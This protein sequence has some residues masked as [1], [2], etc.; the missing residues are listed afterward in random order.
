MKFTGIVMIV[1]SS[2]LIGLYQANKLAERCQTVQEV[3]TLIRTVKIEMHY[4]ATT[5]REL[6]E[7]L[8]QSSEFKRLNFFD[9]CLERYEEG[10]DQV[11]EEEVGRAGLRLE[12]EDVEMLRAFGASLGATDLDGQMELCAAFEAKFQDRLRLYT[13]EKEKRSRL[14]VSSGVLVG[15]GISILLL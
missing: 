12:P 4:R 15:I 7:T 3:L 5:V 8:C 2:T 1:L 11:W 9:R 14:Y 13:E 10:F 6:L